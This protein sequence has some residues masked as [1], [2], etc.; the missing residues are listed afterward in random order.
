M[1]DKLC[2]VLA[3]PPEESGGETELIEIGRL[4]RRHGVRGEIRLRPYNPDSATLQPPQRVAL[5][6]DGSGVEW[7][8]VTALRRHQKYL[9]LRFEGIESAN[10][11]DA[12]IGR[13]LFVPR[14]QLPEL[15]EDEI[16]HCD[17]IGCRVVTDG[18][19]ELGAVAEILS[20]GSNDVLVIRDGGREYLVPWIDDV[21]V[22]VDTAAALIT[23]HPLPGLLDP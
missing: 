5:A 12:L 1:V 7:I 10:D 8:R 4:V 23:I 21:V 19:D 11:A 16:Y 14:D 9:L 18:G 15:G 6:A 17:L 2:D 22:E 3:A 13:T 20:T